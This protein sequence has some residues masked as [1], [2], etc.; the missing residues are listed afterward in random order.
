MKTTVTKAEET[1]GV[2]SNQLPTNSFAVVV[3]APTESCIKPGAI[4]YLGIVADRIY[5]LSGYQTET[6]RDEH[7]YEPLV[8]GDKLTIE[9]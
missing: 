6:S 7:R 4:A 3:S 5:F 9:I 1:R 2:R 8:K